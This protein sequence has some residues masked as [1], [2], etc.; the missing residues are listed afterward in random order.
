MLNSALIG[1]S[2]CSLLLVASLS[3]RAEA[4]QVEPQLLMQAGHPL[5]NYAATDAAPVLRRG[6]TG[7]PVADVQRFLKQTGLYNGAIDGIFGSE[8]D[9]GVEQFQKQANLPADGIVGFQIW[10]AMINL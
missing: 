2:A 3:V 4:P 9:A 6:E 7:Q 10:K 8:T 1:L 5:S